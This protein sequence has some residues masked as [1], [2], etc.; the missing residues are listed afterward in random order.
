MEVLFPHSAFAGIVGAGPQ[1]L[2]CLLFSVLFGWNSY[3]LKGSSTGIS[4]MNIM[5]PVVI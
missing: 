5:F 4:L 1:F 2:F 3:S